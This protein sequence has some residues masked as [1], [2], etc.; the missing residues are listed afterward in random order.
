MPQGLEINDSAG[1]LV[2]GLTDDILKIF[3]VLSIGQS[4]TGTN[5]T[6]TLTDSRFTAYSGSA[7]FYILIAG[8]QY[9]PRYDA[10]IS[11]SG[12]VLTWTFPSTSLRPDSVFVYGVY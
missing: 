4:Y 1:N 7:S 12:N 2:L 8:E 3:G 11:I 6:G 5:Q 10:A 9:N